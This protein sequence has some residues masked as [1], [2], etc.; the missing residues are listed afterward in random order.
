MLLGMLWRW[1]GHGVKGGASWGGETRELEGGLV[2]QWYGE[3]EG[4][5]V[6]V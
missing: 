3:G 5:V 1:R 4:I 6:V 2:T